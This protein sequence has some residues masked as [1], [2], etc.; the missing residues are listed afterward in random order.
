MCLKLLV[1]VIEME[2]KFTWV[3]FYTEF[4]NKLLQYKDDR[5][6]LIDKIKEVTKKLQSNNISVKFKLLD[7]GTQKGFNDIDPFTVFSWINSYDKNRKYLIREIK[8]EYNV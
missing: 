6:K 1:G 3:G 7:D 5:M 8:K 4:A 2:D